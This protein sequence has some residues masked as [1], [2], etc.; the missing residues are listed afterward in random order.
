MKYTIELE[1]NRP[2]CKVTTLDNHLYI[3]EGYELFELLKTIEDDISKFNRKD[4]HQNIFLKSKKTKD[5]VLFKNVDEL[6]MPLRDFYKEYTKKEIRREQA[7]EQRKAKILTKAAVGV[8]ASTIVTNIILSEVGLNKTEVNDSK[9]STSYDT[10]TKAEENTNTLKVDNTVVNIPELEK[11][12]INEEVETEPE[13]IKN[14]EQI[15]LEVNAKYDQ[16][17]ND[18]VMP[19][20]NEIEARANKW[21]ISKELMFDIISQEY[22]GKGNNLTHVIFDS[23]ENQVLNVYNFE[24]NQYETVVI[25]N[26]PEKYKNVNHVITE[27]DLSNYKTNI[28]VGAIILQ[29]SLSCFNYN[30]SLGIQ[31]YNNGTGAVNKIIEE[32]SRM[33]G[34]T[35]E[36]IIASKEP[37]W[38]NYTYVIEKGDKIYFQNVVK[39]INGDQEE[40]KLNDVYSIQYVDNDEVKTEEVQYKL[41]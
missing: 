30:I 7:K 14:I 35:K 12:T 32:T 24:S 33:T 28:S 6:E 38:L 29:Y 27:A 15:P 39:H 11:V 10:M 9:V 2:L 13:E 36:E 16:G 25:T 37:I 41:R 18:R 31:A 40:S 3:L 21:G 17:I 22:G 20:I 26:N 1:N 23:W 8:I 19:Y 5:V 4:I 34:K